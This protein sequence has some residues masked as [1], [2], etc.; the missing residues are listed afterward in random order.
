MGNKQSVYKIMREIKNKY[1]IDRTY[2][3]VRNEVTELHLTKHKNYPEWTPEKEEKLA[4]LAGK[5]TLKQLGKILGH[6]R[7]SVA[8]KMQAMKMSNYCRDGWYTVKDL[9]YIFGVCDETVNRWIKRDM[10]KAKSFGDTKVKKIDQKEL[11][12]FVLKYPVELTS[13]NIQ[14]ALYNAIISPEYY[15][16]T[17]KED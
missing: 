15:T 1:G 3:A 9:M 2:S 4:E 7:D 5:H 17:D 10:L 14:L 6:T 16:P 13:R 8:H 12:K 11:K